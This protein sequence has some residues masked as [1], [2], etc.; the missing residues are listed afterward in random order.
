M[1]RFTPRKTYYKLLVWLLIMAVGYSGT[2]SVVHAEAEGSNMITEKPTLLH[3]K[4]VSV[5]ANASE[6]EIQS[7]INSVSTAGGGTVTLA[8]GTYKISTP[9]L[10]K[11]NVALVGAGKGKTVLQISAN[12]GANGVLTAN[13]A[14]PAV[15][16]IVKNL[17]VDGLKPNDPN[18]ESDVSAVTNYGILLEGESYINNKVLFDNIEIKNTNMGLHIKGSTNITVQNSEIHDNGGYYNFWHNVYLRR[19]SKVLITNCEIYNSHTGNGV[20]IS[21]SEYVTINDSE[22]YDNYFRGVRVADSIHM[23]TINNVVYGNKTGDGIIYNSEFTGVSNFTISGN[24]VSDNYGYGIF[25]NGF[26]SNGD[27]ISNI[28]GGGNAKG[29]IQNYGKEIN[30]QK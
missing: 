11:S 4:D 26:S 16:V 30:I 21:Y 10:L 18:V 5:G 19:V 29:Y 12:L 13:N 9:I 15:N 22:I 28:D 27:V 8:N 1:K 14:N 17:T 2:Y 3:A 7:A 25:T 24:N 23:D 20:N 6:S